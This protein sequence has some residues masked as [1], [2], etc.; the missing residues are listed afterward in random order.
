MRFFTR[1]DRSLSAE[2]SASLGGRC[3]VLA[4]GE[5]EATV[6][7]GTRDH[8]ALRSDGVW[9]AWPWESV[10]KGSWRAEERAFNWSTM[11]GEEF[12]VVLE[13]AG[14]LPELFR[15]RVQASTVVEETFDVPGGSVRLVGRRSPHGDGA[16]KVYAVPRG[17]VSLDDDA[18]RELVVAQSDRLQADY[19]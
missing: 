6:L 12:D 11:A 3:D 9:R 7:A 10:A 8:L 13:D 14:R 18:V 17:F 4:H 19:S 5:G 2:L 16:L 1:P 15:E